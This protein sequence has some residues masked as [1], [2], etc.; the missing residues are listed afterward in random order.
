MTNETFPITQRRELEARLFY[1]NTKEGALADVE[2]QK[3]R[4]LLMPEIADGRIGADGN[5]LLW[6]NWLNALSIKATGMIKDKP[7]V[8]YAHVPNAFSTSAGI[9]EAKKLGLRNRAG[10]LPGGEFQRLYDLQNNENVFV[11]DYNALR[12]STSDVI[13]VSDAL[14]HPQT[15]PFLGGEETAVNYLEFYKRVLGDKIGNWHVDDLQSDGKA[16]ARLLYVGYFDGLDGSDLD[17]DARFVGVRDVLA[18]SNIGD[19]RYSL[20]AVTSA[21]QGAGVEG[22]LRNRVIAGLPANMVQN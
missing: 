10:I 21:L 2:S 16:V 14:K 8:I 3:S 1:G 6:K 17:S 18:G 5:S 19:G 20:E 22:E 4:A 11:V 9:V 13:K 7:V 15:I 12:S